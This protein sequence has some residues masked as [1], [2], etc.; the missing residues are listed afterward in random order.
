MN[1]R[2]RL[3][4]LLI[5][6]SLLRLVSLGLYPLA[7][8]TEARYGNIARLMAETGDWITPQYAPGVPFW[9]KPPLATWLSAASMRLFGINEFAA[10]LPS[11]VLALTVIGLVWSLAARRCGRDRALGAV[12]VLMSS[13]LFFVSG[14]AVMTD[15]SL[16]LAT[17]LC[18]VSFWQAMTVD[19][20]AGRLWGYAFFVGL[21]LGLLAKGPVAVVLTGLPIGLWILWQRQWA[22][23]RQRLPW[24]GGT[25]LA[26]ALCV[27]W[28]WL[29]ELKTPGFLDYF[30]VGEHWKRFTV[31]GWK[32]DLYGSAHLQPK[33]TIW[34]H[35]LVGT[36]PWS[37]ILPFSLLG[38]KTRQ[39]FHGL[40]S[41]GDGWLPY[42]VLWAVTP[43]VFFTLAGNILWTYVLPGLPAFA[44]LVAEL[45]EGP[46]SLRQEAPRS[47]ATLRWAASCM[48]IL[49]ALLLT[50]LTLGYGPAEKSQKERQ[51]ALTYLYKLPYSAQFYSGGAALL[52]PSLDEVE[53]LFQDES[54]NYFAIRKEDLGRLTSSF[55]AQVVKL[56]P[57]NRNYLLREKDVTVDLV[58]GNQIPV[59][60]E[61]RIGSSPKFL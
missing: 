45:L 61:P 43:M 28:Y 39:R 34:L 10:R 29:A 20:R 60:V 3:W 37:L 2:R 8:T 58:A 27:P 30:L 46:L 40:V 42:L 5:G 1:S 56:G 36:L 23:V 11:F 31:P 25:V 7:D 57:I 35:W 21:A 13:A 6:L 16:L 48:T 47:S 52:A 59:P 53:K 15:P 55:L 18:M 26:A 38:R 41:Q 51:E 33:G 9:G 22:V 17:T 49:F 32:G 50:G 44:L 12:V 4:V 24:V 14:G 19:G 54:V